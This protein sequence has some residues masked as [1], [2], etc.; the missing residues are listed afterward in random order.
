MSLATRLI[1]GQRSKVNVTG[2][3]GAKRISIEGDRVI[4]VSLRS[5]ECPPSSS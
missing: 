1:L 4:C 5:I 3:Q 2:S